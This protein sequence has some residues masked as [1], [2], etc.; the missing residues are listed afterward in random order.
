MVHIQPTGFQ[1]VRKGYEKPR[2][3]GAMFRCMRVRSA[4]G[5]DAGAMLD[6]AEMVQRDLGAGLD[7]GAM[8][9]TSKRILM[10]GD[11]LGEGAARMWRGLS[12]GQ[13]SPMLI[14]SE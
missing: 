5:L 6:G 1:E 13:Q 4:A 3:S 2:M 9:E 11:A 7:A 14:I 8:L 12:P 10:P